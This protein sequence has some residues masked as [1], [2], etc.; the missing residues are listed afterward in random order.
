MRCSANKVQIQDHLLYYLDKLPIL[1]KF[2]LL[3]NSEFDY[4]TI[5]LTK[6]WVGATFGICSMSNCKGSKN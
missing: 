1:Q 3:K 2:K 6:F 4:L 5:I